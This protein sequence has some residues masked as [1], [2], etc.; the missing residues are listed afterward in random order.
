MSCVD[1]TNSLL[2]INYT[3]QN[4]TVR[5]IKVKRDINGNSI[6]TSDGHYQADVVS[7]PQTI[8]QSAN[9]EDPKIISGWGPDSGYDGFTAQTADGINS[10]TSALY[11][12]PYPFEDSGAPCYTAWVT[13]CFSTD[14]LVN[15]LSSDGT[16]NG[17]QSSYIV[18]SPAGYYITEPESSGEQGSGV[19][20]DTTPSWS[21]LHVF[22][23][24]LVIVV[25]AVFVIFAI[26]KY[27]K[28]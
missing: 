26:R 17:P 23:F 19:N 27:R 8:T 15:C 20:P 7:E 14:G 13:L 21:L 25:A 2:F 6:L 1:G 4:V 9:G 24:I 28:K 10:V 18:L 5:F 22:I 16:R 12:G 11:D 3:Q